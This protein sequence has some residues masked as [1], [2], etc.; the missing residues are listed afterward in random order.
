MIINQ[1]TIYAVLYS[2]LIFYV[3]GGEDMAN[4]DQRDDAQSYE[5]RM[6]RHLYRPNIHIARALFKMFFPICL[7]I[8]FCV[9]AN[10]YDWLHYLENII[11]IHISAIMLGF[12]FVILYLAL[13]MR[14]IIIWL[15]RFYQRYAPED[16]RRMCHFVPSCSEYMVLAIEKYGVIRGINKG[17]KRL[18]RCYGDNGGIDM[19]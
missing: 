14:S 19:P 9:I 8:I 11:G 17:W 12:T 6:K 2:E 4:V 5:Y 10:E 3:T 1:L 13:R 16:V 7:I 18:L 15:I